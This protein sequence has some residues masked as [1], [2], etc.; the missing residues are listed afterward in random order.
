MLKNSTY[1]DDDASGPTDRSQ[2]AVRGR[3]VEGSWLDSKGAGDINVTSQLHVDMAW[4][5]LKVPA[6]IDD[7]AVFNKLQIGCVAQ[8]VERRSL[9]GELT[10][11]CA[12]P[13]A[14][15]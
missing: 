7:P 4:A 5:F 9:A 2:A 6:G 1:I 3:G 11:S 8:L 14:D 10:L 13:A 12:R 15:G